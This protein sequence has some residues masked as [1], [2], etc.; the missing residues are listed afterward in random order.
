MIVTRDPL[1]DDDN[2]QLKLVS[3]IHL[4][5][6]TPLGR[7]RTVVVYPCCP[8]RDPIRVIL[9]DPVAAEF[10]FSNELSMTA[11]KEKA[12]DNELVRRPRVMVVKRV[13]PGRYTE[14]IEN[15]AVWDIHC[16]AMDA[17]WPRLRL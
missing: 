13:L 6:S 11:L 3:D 14:A 2:L 1:K 15:T 12:S 10:D 7:C 4:L 9:E 16:V 17:L 8:S 5:A